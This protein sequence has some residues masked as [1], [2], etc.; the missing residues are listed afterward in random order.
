MTRK[1]YVLIAGA[2]KEVYDYQKDSDGKG[3][4]ALKQGAIK[5]VAETLADELGRDNFRFDRNRFLEACGVLTISN[6]KIEIV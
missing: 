6:A 4:K 3:S 2:I 1:D 5:V